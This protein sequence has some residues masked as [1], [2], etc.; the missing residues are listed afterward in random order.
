MRRLAT[1]VKQGIRAS[2][3]PTHNGI[4]AMTHC[5]AAPVQ[6]KGFQ[7]GKGNNELGTNKK[8]YLW[9]DKK[10]QKQRGKRSGCKVV[11]C[12]WGGRNKDG[13]A[14]LGCGMPCKE[15]GQ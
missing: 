7:E 3:R 14:V 13:T 11:R 1:S 2:G 6:K 12:L 10:S 4:C 15:G 8:L 5:A 9:G